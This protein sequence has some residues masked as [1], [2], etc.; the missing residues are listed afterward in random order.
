MSG[1]SEKAESGIK[2]VHL[3]F[4]VLEAVAAEQGEIGVFEIALQIGSAWDLHC[5]PKGKSAA[6]FGLASLEGELAT[7]RRR[8]FAKAG[9]KE[10]FGINERSAPL[11]NETGLGF[12]PPG[13]R[14]LDPAH[15]A[16]TIPGPDQRHPARRANDLT[17]SGVCR[18][19]FAGQF[20]A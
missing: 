20:A 12:A 9:D 14:R 7:C 2:A 1:T 15:S 17:Q 11:S 13:H 16:A 3:A 4:D 5:T 18:L 19:G 6:A 10:T 8:G